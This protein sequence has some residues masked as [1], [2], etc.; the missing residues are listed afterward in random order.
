MYI[1]QKVYDEIVF[2][3]GNAPI[4][5]G[6][7]IGEKD[8]VICEYFFDKKAKQNQEKYVPSLNLLNKIIERWHENGIN[9]I[10][11]V[12]SHPNNYKRPSLNDEKYAQ[13][14][15]K[16]NP[17]LSRLIFPIVTVS[18]DNIEI[19]FFEFTEKFTRVNISVL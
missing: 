7:I 19:V 5:S 3:I 1:S 14:L 13:K 11:I 4:E 15:M 12:H 17:H 2:T 10:G 8:G 6:G 18:S 9:F 16:C